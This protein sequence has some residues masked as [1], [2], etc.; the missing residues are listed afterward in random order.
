MR[1][2]VY[3]RDTR[4][5]SAFYRDYVSLASAVGDI[6]VNNKSEDLPFISIL[7]DEVNSDS[8]HTY[9]QCQLGGS[10]E[11]EERLCV[12]WHKSSD[13][14]HLGKS[15]IIFIILV[16]SLTPKSDGEPLDEN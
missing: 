6:L 13:H 12:N 3:Y 15:S 9:E 5:S 11:K 2:N 4:P 8:A 10:G 14:A 16:M 7:I 1:A